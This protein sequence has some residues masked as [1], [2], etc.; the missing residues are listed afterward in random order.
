M[1][2]RDPILAAIG[3]VHAAGSVVR[4]NRP[5]RRR[6]LPRVHL[7]SPRHR[8]RGAGV[9]SAYHNHTGRMADSDDNLSDIPKSVFDN[10][11]HVASR[12]SMRQ[13]I[14]RR[15]HASEVS[16]ILS[17]SLLILRCL[18]SQASVR[19]ATHRRGR[20]ANPRS[21]FRR[22]AISSLQPVASFTQSASFPAYPP[23]A[24]IRSSLGNCPTS[25]SITNFAP[26]RSWIF[27]G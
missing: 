12:L 3:G 23:S 27:A 25:F 24:H 11:V 6:I 2:I 16:A 9:R 4:N 7:D 13:I 5:A 26:S 15:I 22:L 18:P 10:S 19:S 21:P 17:Q 8:N 20:T 1:A 14:A